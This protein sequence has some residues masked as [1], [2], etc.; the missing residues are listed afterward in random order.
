MIKNDQIRKTRRIIDLND[1]EIM[2]SEL[3]NAI[4]EKKNDELQSFLDDFEY[5]ANRIANIDI[6]IMFLLES[7]EKIIYIQPL[8]CISRILVIINSAIHIIDT[9]SRIKYEF[10][11]LSII[12]EYNYPE[13]IVEAIKSLRTLVQRFDIQ[14]YTL[15]SVLDLYQKVRL[16]TMFGNEK[17][18]ID[19]QFDETIKNGALILIEVLHFMGDYVCAD[20]NHGST[21]NQTMID[22]LI[23]QCI[24]SIENISSASMIIIARVSDAMPSLLSERLKLEDNIEIFMDMLH[25][26]NAKEEFFFALYKTLTILVKDNDSDYIGHLV[27]LGLFQIIQKSIQVIEQ[28][29]TNIYIVGYLS[30]NEDCFTYF[31]ERGVIQE[32]LIDWFNNFPVK[33]MRA[34][35]FFFLVLC[36]KI[37]YELLLEIF[38][39]NMFANKILDYLEIVN[40][41]DIKKLIRSMCKIIIKEKSMGFSSIKRVFVDEKLFETL[42]SFVTLEEY[43][44]HPILLLESILNS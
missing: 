19:Q 39:N 4:Q 2:F 15:N 17:V 38:T 21:Y 35:F 16:E 44:N 9:E 26:L 23:K 40:Q 1:S 30:R 43:P 22:Y 29:E 11:L 13:M 10:L 7:V 32:F 8:S 36:K 3:Y 14:E 41:K 6:S 33:T 18:S 34:L 25:Q 31:W 27:S 24:S 28:M 42:K 12:E 5:Q 37:P 20:R